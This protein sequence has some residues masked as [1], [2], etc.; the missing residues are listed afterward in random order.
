MKKV[1]VLL[2][3]VM[4]LSLVGCAD[5]D[6]VEDVKKPEDIVVQ[7]NKKTDNNVVLEDP[8]E[9]TLYIPDE[10]FMKMETKI[11][12]LDAVD[13][14]LIINALIKENVLRE[15]C[16]V[17]SL[18]INETNLDLDLNAA[19]GEHIMGMGTTGEYFSLGCIV[20]T[21]LDAFDKEAI[22][23]TV[24]GEVLESGHSTYEGYL[25]KFNVER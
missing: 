17:N 23:I 15:G 22:N 24:D 25:T 16:K 21:F 12:S 20:N 3:T 8:V 14:E 19:F 6:A 18:N 9:V 2:T 13:A 11:V 5:K 1:I 10:N 7:E 4:L